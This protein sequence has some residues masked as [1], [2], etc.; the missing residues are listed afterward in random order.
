MQTMQ[1]L[2]KATTVV[3]LV[4]FYPVNRL[5]LEARAGAWS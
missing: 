4:H 2:L 1:Q 3:A 5:R